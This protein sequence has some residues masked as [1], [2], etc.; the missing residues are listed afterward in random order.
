DRQEQG[1]AAA[2]GV[3]RPPP[4]R[5]PGI[6]GREAPTG[7]APDR[8]RPVAR[9]AGSGGGAGREPAPGVQAVAALQPAAQSGRAVL[10][11]AAAA[12]D[13]QPA[14]R[15]TGRPQAVGPQ[16]PPLLPDHAATGP[17]LAR[18]EVGSINRIVNEGA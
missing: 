15:Y 8:Q 4:A 11:G 5:R 16:Q 3:R 2:G 1:P 13:A 9:R 12:G 7:G 14:V 6:P 17:T 18:S 10:E